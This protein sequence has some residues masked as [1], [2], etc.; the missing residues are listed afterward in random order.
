[1]ESIHNVDYQ[2]LQRRNEVLLK[3]IEIISSSE[4]VQTYISRAF[5]ENILF[6][7]LT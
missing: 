6:H 5:S 3:V 1:M 7:I 4:N 2:L